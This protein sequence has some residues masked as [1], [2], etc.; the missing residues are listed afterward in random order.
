MI[1]FLKPW[2]IDSPS[3]ACRGLNATYIASID[4]GK[5][6]DQPTIVTENATIHEPCFK[7]N[8]ELEGDLTYPLIAIQMGWLLYII[9]FVIFYTPKRYNSFL[10]WLRIEGDTIHLLVESF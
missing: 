1:T 2:E 9:F 10:K 4:T 7:K 6:I 3:V 5:H 8:A